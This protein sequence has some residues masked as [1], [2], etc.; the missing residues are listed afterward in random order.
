MYS[1]TCCSHSLMGGVSTLLV[2]DTELRHRRVNRIA[3]VTTDKERVGI[4]TYVVQP[5]TG[6]LN[7]FIHSG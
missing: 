5:R 3:M 6:L 2:T 7:T 4:Q 1:L